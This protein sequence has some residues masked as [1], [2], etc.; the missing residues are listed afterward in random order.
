MLQAKGIMQTKLLT[1]SKDATISEAI[2][3]LAENGITGMP[4][5][6]DD[7]GIVGLISEKDLLNVAFHIMNGDG[8]AALKGKKVE[9][10]M[11]TDVVSFKTTSNVADICQ[12]FMNNSFRRVPILEDDK[13]VGLI[14]RKDIIYKTF[15]KI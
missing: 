4:V 5:V 14:S 13:L 1:I 6:D 8:D 11:T 2:K 12:C 10:I 7:M 3:L 9:D 15:E